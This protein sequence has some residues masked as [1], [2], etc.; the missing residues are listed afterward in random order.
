MEWVQQ[1]AADL[2]LG[3]AEPFMKVFVAGGNRLFWLYL[4]VAGLIAYGLYRRQAEKRGGFQPL[5][6]RSE[7][8]PTSGSMM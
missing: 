6:S 4:L 8:Q 1:V 2:L 7:I 3:L 5:T